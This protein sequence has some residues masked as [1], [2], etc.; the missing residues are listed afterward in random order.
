MDE[1]GEHV[2]KREIIAVVVLGMLAG[3]SSS[4][5]SG[6]V[7]SDSGA[8]S[9]TAGS[10]DSGGTPA[11]MTTLP[12][13]TLLDQLSVA[14]LQTMCTDLDNYR[15]TLARDATFKP[16]LC[17]VDGLEA[18]VSVAGPSASDADVQP[19]TAHMGDLVS[20]VFSIYTFAPAA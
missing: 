10:T 11:F 15:K 19:E 5:S 4:G 17:K 14:Q 13:T 7:S 8:S 16:W 2:G 12:G 6:V 20:P 18:A 3:C 9:D 1:G